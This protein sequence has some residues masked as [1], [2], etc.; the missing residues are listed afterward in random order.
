MTT[1]TKAPKKTMPTDYPFEVKFMEIKDFFSDFE[2]YQ[3]EKRERFIKK[4]ATEENFDP[5]LVHV[6]AV[7]L[8]EVGD[9]EKAIVDGHKTYAIIDGQQRDTMLKIMGYTHAWCAVYT[10]LTVRQEALLFCKLNFD[11]NNVKSWDHYKA[12]RTAEN[13]IV[14]GV[15]RLCAKFGFIVVGD[16]YRVDTF[17][18][19]KTLIDIYAASPEIFR[20]V[21]EED[22]PRQL[23]GPEVLREI[24]VLIDKI[25]R[26]GML[27]KEWRI[28]RSAALLAG[29]GR[30]FFANPGVT[31][32]QL[33]DALTG[34]I[35]NNIVQQADSRGGGHGRGVEE[36]IQEL[37]DSWGDEQT[38]T[39]V[40]KRQP[41]PKTPSGSRVAVAVA[42]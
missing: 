32:L 39:A 30:F 14:L 20:Q 9:G 34:V 21:C 35:P 1:T 17:G 7:S 27:Q 26:R 8:R 13:P 5:A 11:R 22:R 16:G 41:K 37:W 40:K 4:H 23:D 29:L 2:W 10:G 38:R 33:S 36:I 42:A 12:A 31:G 24:F 25:W 3:R 6:L 15:D 18:C 28:A 19:C